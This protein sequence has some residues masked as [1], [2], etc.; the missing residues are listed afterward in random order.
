MPKMRHRETG[1]R[2][3]LKAWALAWKQ[4]ISAANLK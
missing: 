4:D 2:S 1:R 3:A